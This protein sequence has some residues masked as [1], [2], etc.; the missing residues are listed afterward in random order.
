MEST[1]SSPRKIAN[2]FEEI[3]PPSVYAASSSAPSTSYDVFINHYGEDVKFTL[4]TNIHAKLKALGLS[5]FLDV[6]S[7][8]IGDVIPAHIQDAMRSASIHI[9]ILSPNYAESPWCLAELSFMLMTTKRI[10]PIFYHVD[11]ADLR[12]GKG[13]YAPAFSRHEE[14]RR[15]SS[16]KVEEW[17]TALAKISNHIGFVVKDN[18]DEGTL[19]KNIVNMVSKGSWEW[20][21]W[22]KPLWPRSSTTGSPRL[23]RDAAIKNALHKKQK[24][25]LKDIGVKDLDFNDIEEGKAILVNR[26]RPVSA[27]IVLDDVDHKNQLDALIPTR[28]CLGSGSVVIVTT[29]LGGFVYGRP[30]DY[31]V[32]QLDK[33]FRILPE[34]I[35]GRLS[36]SY[37][38]LD[39]EEKEMF[40]DV[41][42]FFVGQQRSVAIEAWNGS[43]WSGLQGWETLVNKCLVNVDEDDNI[44]MHD[45]LLD[46]GRDFAD[47][48]EDE[49]EEEN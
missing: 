11:P 49:D 3:V 37:N 14:Q 1:S 29:R 33:I 22:A 47:A 42:C 2:P 45:H 40:M 10:V 19:L 28:D 4:A 35:K 5:V 48:D 18:K 25:L 32:S 34:D 20:V 13:I 36:L 26:L 44:T 24:K 8:Q 6:H 30:R 46:L 9:A 23:S 39:E 17:K 7:L 12:W 41:A 27:L 15:Y 21:E 38:A 43:G 16:K 31:W